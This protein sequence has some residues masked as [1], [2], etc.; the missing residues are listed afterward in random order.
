MLFAFV[1]WPIKP[2]ASNPEVK[3]QC[4]RRRQ[5]WIRPIRTQPGT[6]DAAAPTY[7]RGPVTD[8]TRTGDGVLSFHGICIPQWE[9]PPPPKQLESFVVHC[10]GAVAEFL[11]RLQTIR[12]ELGHVSSQH[13]KAQTESGVLSSETIG[14]SASPQSAEKVAAVLHEI[15]ILP[16]GDNARKLASK[17]PDLI[18]AVIREMPIDQA[19]RMVERFSGT[20][21]S[22]LILRMHSRR[23]SLLI[24]ALDQDSS[25]MRKD[26]RWFD[27]LIELN[28]QETRSLITSLTPGAAAALLSAT[29]L[30]L[31][32]DDSSN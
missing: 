8:G 16:Y 5:G 14:G 12:D 9:P 21:T 30:S 32:A 13:S 17:D 24:E 15:S 19:A 20:L 7:C 3:T 22:R 11:L 18:L 10:G 29:P 31:R 25:M 26:S 23:A 6:G 4:R 2:T 27:V 28:D 1:R